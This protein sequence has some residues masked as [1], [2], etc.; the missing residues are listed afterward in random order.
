M[1]MPPGE[2]VRPE[3]AEVLRR[4]EERFGPRFSRNP[5]VRE[6]HGR[7]EAWHPPRPPDAVVFVENT[8]EVAWTVRLCHEAGVPVVPFGAGTSLEGHVAALRGGVCI[9]LTGMNRVLEVNVADMD[10]R[11]QPGVTRRQ[12]ERELH[13]T[14][15]FFPVDPGAD[16]TLG[17]MAATRATGTTTVRYGGMR[18]NVLALEVVLA[19]GRVIRTGRRARK[20]SAGYD[21]TRLFLGSEGTLGIVTELTLRLW[22]VPEAVAAA[23]CGFPSVEDAVAAVVE[24]L[25]MAVPVARIELLDELQM[26]ACI[27][28]AKLEGFAAVP[29]LFYEFHGSEAAVRGA[30]AVAGEVAAAHGG[31]AFRW[32]LAAEERN[33]LWRARHDAYYAAL[34]LRP[35]AVAWVTDVCVPISRLPDQIRA[36]R[37]EIRESGIPATVVGHVGDGNF[38]VL[39]LVDPRH[40]REWETVRELN[41]RMVERALEAGGT[42]TGEHGVGIGKKAALLAE[43]G[44]DAV[45]VM[46]AIKRALDPRGILN[47]GKIFD[48]PQRQG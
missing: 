13:D 17:G 30:A 12:L 34:A 19:D 45:E 47:P 8:E 11:V 7:G 24:T 37:E 10:C 42:C 40:P 38:H 35:G 25:A 9:D 15:L 44:E 27:R 48:L 31:A 23:V 39:F 21:L 28:H 22:P 20:S 41:R 16:A 3:L 43:L 46:R 14:G 2:E 32:A 1:E 6:Q 29:T 33:R 5:S 18:E 4:L 36:A 26:E